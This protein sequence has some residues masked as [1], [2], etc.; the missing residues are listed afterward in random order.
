[1][2]PHQQSTNAAQTRAPHRHLLSKSISDTISLF[3]SEGKKGQE[4]VDNNHFKSTAYKSY[5]TR[6]TGTRTPVSGATTCA[7]TSI[8]W[9]RAP[10]VSN[11]GM[12]VR[13]GSAAGGASPSEAGVCKNDHSSGVTPGGSK[14]RCLV[15]RE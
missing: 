4:P 15:C 3:H 7:T 13:L 9:E 1:M 12:S 6:S 14:D 11:S 5:L 2:S 10:I 8:S